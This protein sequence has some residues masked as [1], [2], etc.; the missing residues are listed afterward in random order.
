MSTPDYRI[1]WIDELKGFIL[2]IV[3]I[4]HINISSSIIQ[5]GIAISLGFQMTSFF[6]LSGIL[7]NASRYPT[8]ASYLIN[9]NRSLL[10][11]YILLS[12]L[13][14]FLDP[15]FYNINFIQLDHTGI[16]NSINNSLE[17]LHLNLLN[18][19]YFG[20]SSIITGPLW[21]VFS[22][23]FINIF[24]SFLYYSFHK[25]RNIKILISCIIF[26]LLGWICNIYRINLPF[27][28][29]T[30]S[31]SYF[32]FC[33]GYFCKDLY[34]S[35]NNNKRYFIFL[36]CFSS[37]II[38]MISININGNIHLHSNTLG[39]N[40]LFYII[41]TLSGISFI[42][43][44]FTLINN[45]K[46]QFTNY[47]YGILR[48]IANNGLIILAVHHWTYRCC[49][50]FLHEYINEYWFSYLS[51]LIVTITCTISIPV[52]RNKLYWMIGKNKISIKESLSIK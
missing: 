17:Y 7:Y 34:L 4:E 43:L 28:L 20:N 33:C 35:I 14:I 50:I 40:F 51:L 25:H 5:T 30:T 3:C 16:P 47:I 21:F 39:T 31:T 48:L 41:T 8:Y 2:L 10:Y 23:Y 1:E 44:T 19:F 38:Y 45:I 27:N 36:L 49:R 37:A 9:K 29:D 6:F 46:H 32:F 42:T 52:F 13:F 26:L 24:F 15:R 11:P 18:I 22:L 12:L